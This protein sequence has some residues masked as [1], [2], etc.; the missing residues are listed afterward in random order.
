[1]THRTPAD[2]LGDPASGAWPPLAELSRMLRTGATSSAE[3]TGIALARI[4][5]RDP[6]LSSVLA[7]DPRAADRARAADRRLRRGSARPLEGIPVLVKDNIGTAGLATTAGSR[8][9]LSCPPPADAAV[10]AALR[11]AGAVTV[12][13]TNLSE[14]GN[15]RSTKGIEGWSAV[16]GQTRNPHHLGYSPWGSSSGSAAAIA[17]G[18][19]PLALG[20][21]TDGSIVCPAAVCGV[22]GLKPAA[23]TLPSTGI[24]P[25]APGQDTPGVLATRVEDAAAAFAA[26][27]PGEPP[28]AHPASGVRLGIWTGRRFDDAAHAALANVA[29]RL[30]DRGVPLTPVELPFDR[31]R[32]DDGLHA[33]IAGFGPALDSYLRGRPGA[34]AGLE[35]V[36]AANR[37]D[38]DELTLFDQD[39]MELAARATARE[40]ATV[41]AR[42]ARAR[43]WASDVLRRVL[44]DNAVDAVVA[45]TAP[46]AWPLDHGG[47]DPAAPSTSTLAALAG[48][49]V[50]TVP[51]GADALLPTGVSVFGP[52]ETGRVL[53]IAALVERVAGDRRTPTY[54]TPATVPG[55]PPR[56]GD[57]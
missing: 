21:E 33:M 45:P 19:A 29:D 46:P 8:L 5:E 39:L 34:P 13:K 55:E 12:G 11:A 37:A 2:D 51:T 14:W 44:D 30:R 32:L 6:L 38:P 18:L 3:L 54:A 17:A 15:F 53:A 9:L 52:E 48:R 41:P 49:P 4:A 26:L 10:V 47:G 1:M 25:I 20:T 24:V 35:A 27:R 42:R 16:G 56:T 57:R 50:V 40:R 22:V 43:S 28:A 7:L 23:D 31:E 36:I